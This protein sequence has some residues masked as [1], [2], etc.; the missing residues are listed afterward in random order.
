VSPPFSIGDDKP[1]WTDRSCRKYNNA[2]N[3]DIRQ[4]QEQDQKQVEDFIFI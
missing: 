4:Q 3:E 2:D 1:D